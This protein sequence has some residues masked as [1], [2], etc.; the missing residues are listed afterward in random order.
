MTN[1]AISN[2]QQ[3]KYVDLHYILKRH[4]S[5][6]EML[7]TLSQQI[8]LN[9]NIKCYISIQLGFRD[10]RQNTIMF[11]NPYLQHLSGLNP[12]VM[13][14]QPVDLTYT[15]HRFLSSLTRPHQ[16]HS[17]CK[18]FIFGLNFRICNHFEKKKQCCNSGYT[19]TKTSFRCF[20]ISAYD[21]PF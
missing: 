21:Y 2:V 18:C 9:C 5:Q 17:K 12:S 11:S 8:K 6:R 10:S 19:C 4:K 7:Y 1:Q 16:V 15:T 20:V 3:L 13:T 14:I